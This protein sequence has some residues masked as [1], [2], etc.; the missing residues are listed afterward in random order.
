VNNRTLEG[1]KPCD[2]GAAPMSA[3]EPGTACIRGIAHMLKGETFAQQIHERQGF[4]HLL[5]MDHR[6]LTSFGFPLF[7]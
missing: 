7:R 5:L 2:T 1:E 4:D 3:N 6:D